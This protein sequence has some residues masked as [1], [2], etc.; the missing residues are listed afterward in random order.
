MATTKVSDTTIITING[1]EYLTFPQAVKFIGFDD[2]GVLH[3]RIMR[4]EAIDKKVKD[5]VNALNIE[6]YVFVPF[7]YCK[8]LKKE[9]EHRKAVEKLQGFASSDLETLEKIKELGLTKE[10]IEKL[11]ASKKK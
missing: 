3:Q 10:D 9:E 7:A 2:R 4:E 5:P 8:R 6:K 11:I 1:K